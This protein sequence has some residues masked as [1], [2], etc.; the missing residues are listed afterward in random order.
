MYNQKIVTFGGGT[1]HFNLLNGLK[2][3]NNPTLITAVVASWD[4]G[5]SSGRLRTE[6]GI[7]PPGDIRRCILALMEDDEQQKVAQRLF[8]DRLEKSDGF[9]K[10][11]SLGNLIGA[12]LDHIFHGQDRGTD[13]ERTLFRISA[14]IL[15][16][17]L[18]NLQ[19]VGITKEG[20]NIEGETNLD[21]RSRRSDFD[22]K[23]PIVR[24]HFH[25]RADPNPRVLKAI[26]DA[27]KIVFAPG[28]LFTSIL[29]HL[30]IDGVKEAISSSKAKLC[31]VLNLTTKPGETDA[32]NASDYLEKLVF[33]LGDR[34]RLDYI[35]VNT[36]VLRG[37]I[38][39]IY[40]SVG[41][42]LIKVD[43]KRCKSLA[44]KAKIAKAKLGDYSRKEHLLRHN[45]EKLAK[46][47]LRLP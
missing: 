33:Y 14:K 3:F 5:G 30:L 39:N 9:F 32:F 45:S 24:I 46:T 35:I 22:P 43:E 41:Q 1:G 4:S 44:P 40:K 16:A 23:D 15:P 10:G 20:I 25:T 34:N 6:L 13:A 2:R 17:T 42:E 31:F 21:Y 29:P 11:H 7:L 36:K 37:E 27:D 26:K 19:L 18:T 12:R 8:D 38:V 28:D 47:I